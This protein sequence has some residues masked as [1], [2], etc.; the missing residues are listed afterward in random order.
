MDMFMP[1]VVM[2]EMSVYSYPNSWSRIVVYITHIFLH[3]NHI[4][5]KWF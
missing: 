4:S 2:V 1:L 5:I 3:A